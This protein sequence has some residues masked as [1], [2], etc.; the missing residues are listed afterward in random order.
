MLETALVADLLS[1]RGSHRSLLEGVVLSHAKMVHFVVC[2]WRRICPKLQISM[3]DK[4]AEK[5]V[6]SKPNIS[7]G[8]NGIALMSLELR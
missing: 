3:P 2:M 1:A 4:E 5:G 8:A 6:G 7:F